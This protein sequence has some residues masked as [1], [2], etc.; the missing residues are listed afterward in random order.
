VAHDTTY[1]NGLPISNR[2]WRTCVA[3]E[4]RLPGLL[5]SIRAWRTCATHECR[6]LRTSIWQI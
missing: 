5:F 6:F 3:H 4:R 2:A 1:H